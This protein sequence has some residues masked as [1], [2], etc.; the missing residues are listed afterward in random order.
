MSKIGKCKNC[1]QEN[2][3]TRGYCYDYYAMIF[4]IEKAKQGAFP[5]EVR[6]L[7]SVYGHNCE[8]IK[9]EYLRQLEHRLTIIQDANIPRN[10]IKAIDLEYRI[11][12]AFLLFSNGKK[13]G[14]VNIEINDYLQDE[15]S[16]GFVC[17]LFSRM[18]LLK[19]FKIDSMSLRYVAKG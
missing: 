14:V 12:E 3:L 6:G 8:K 7:Y 10:D 2:I 4:E 1:L 18:I 13:S 17:K 9:E 16:K 11:N 19:R 5:Q 15:K